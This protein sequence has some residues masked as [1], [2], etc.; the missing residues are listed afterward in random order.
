MCLAVVWT[1]NPNASSHENLV[2]WVQTR[3]GWH[4]WSHFSYMSLLTCMHGTQNME[5]NIHFADTQAAPEKALSLFHWLFS[6]R[7]TFENAGLATVSSGLGFWTVMT[8][9][10]GSII[11][12]GSTYCIYTQEM[13]ILNWSFR[14]SSSEL[15]FQDKKDKKIQTWKAQTSML[16]L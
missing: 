6:T 3:P 1:C 14:H 7:L 12:F 2:M 11:F 8:L 15:L 16:N 5:E 9:L 13:T 10:F 4:S